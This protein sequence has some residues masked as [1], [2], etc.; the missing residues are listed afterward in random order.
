MNRWRR[1]FAQVLLAS[2]ATGGAVAL[3]AATVVPE[4]VTTVLTGGYWSDQGREGTYRVVIVR[5]PGEP[6]NSRVFVE[7]LA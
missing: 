7:W 5:E 3:Q 4:S 6:V 2:F 1:L